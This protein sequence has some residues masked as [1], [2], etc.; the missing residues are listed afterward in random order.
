MDRL[1]GGR[2]ICIS[3]FKS[4]DNHFVSASLEFDYNDLK[5]MYF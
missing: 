2:S 5:K 1:G 4:P 3:L